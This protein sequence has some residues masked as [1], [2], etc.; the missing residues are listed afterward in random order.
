[1]NGE[2]K[3]INIGLY[4]ADTEEIAYEIYGERGAAGEEEIIY[5]QGKGRVITET[6]E[7]ETKDLK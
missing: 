3:E 4:A 2:N 1:M 5:S 7:N 6:K